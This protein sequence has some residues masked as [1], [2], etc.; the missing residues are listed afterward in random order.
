MHSLLYWKWFIFW[1]WKLIFF[2][3]N[4]EQ[5]FFDQIAFVDLLTEKAPDFVEWEQTFL[6][7]NFVVLKPKFLFLIVIKGQLWKLS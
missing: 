5:L 3:L 6:V 1:T 4:Q 2:L 7:T